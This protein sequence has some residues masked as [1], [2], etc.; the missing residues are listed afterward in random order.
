MCSDPGQALI[1][2]AIEENKLDRRRRRRLLAAHAREDL[3]QGRR[4][5]GAQ[6]VPVRDGQH[7]RALLLGARG[8]RRGHG[9][10]HRPRPHDRREGPAQPAARGRSRSRSPSAPWSSAAASPASRPRSTSPTAA[11]RSSWSSGSRR[12]AATWPA[13]RDLPHARLLAV[14]PDAADGRGRPASEHQAAH[15]LRGREGRR[16]RRQ[17]RGHHPQEGPLRR[18][19]KCTG[20]GDCWQ[21]ARRRRSPASSTTGWASARRSTCRSRRRCPT[22]R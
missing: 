6:P 12:S 9:Q 18:Q 13:V 15:L 10:G 3:P 11:T 20:C 17:L 19:D 21:S 8:P 22:G 1:R 14:H 5:G 7:P 4:P 16:L 2:E